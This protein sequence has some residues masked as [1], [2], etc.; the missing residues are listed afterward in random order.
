MHEVADS[1]SAD[2]GMLQKMADNGTAVLGGLLHKVNIFSGSES[3][4]DAVRLPFEDGKQE[5]CHDKVEVSHLAFGD[6]ESPT[7]RPVVCN[8]DMESARI[9]VVD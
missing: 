3:Q 9:D 7:L 8:E 6:D 2:K 5:A 4:D 1:H